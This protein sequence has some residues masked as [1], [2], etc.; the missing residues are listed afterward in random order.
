[1]TR[2]NSQNLRERVVL[3]VEQE[4]LSRREAARRYRIGEAMAV[5]WLGAGRRGLRAQGGERRSRLPA[6]EGWFLALIAE[7]N[8]LT[9]VQVAERLLA[10]HGVKAD[11]SMLSRFF[12]RRGI[13]LK[14]R[15]LR[16]RAAAA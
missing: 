8:D 3:A 12:T 11:A 13:S 7:E 16:Q 9:P 14:K 2:A 4:G 10:E 6:H 15:R 5:R 1:M